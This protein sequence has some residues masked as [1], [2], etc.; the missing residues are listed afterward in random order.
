LADSE[1][2]NLLILTSEA[3]VLATRLA[4]DHAVAAVAVGPVGYYN[5]EIRIIDMVGLTDLHV[6][7]TSGG[8]LGTGLAG[9]ENVLRVALLDQKP[10]YILI[11]LGAYVSIPA[12]Q[13][14]WRNERFT[15]QHEEYT[16]GS[17]VGYRLS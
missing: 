2:R 1:N 10:K 17:I 14:M 4:R 11:P 13:A 7:H 5:P 15:S 16:D 6:A 3:R 8:L 9:H 12:V